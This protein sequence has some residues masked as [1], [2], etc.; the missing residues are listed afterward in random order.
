MEALV[1]QQLPTQEVSHEAKK[2][3]VLKTWGNQQTMNLNPLIHSNIVQSHYWKV[4]LKEITSWQQTVDEIY[5]CVTH[6]EPWE[7]GS[8]VKGMSTGGGVRGV[9]V[10][11]IVSTAF[12]LMYKLFTIK[13]TRNQLHALL[14][15]P[16]SPYI[17]GVGFLFIRYCIPPEE[18]WDWVSPYLADDFDI[19]CKA[20][21]GEVITIGQMVEIFFTKL[22]WY[23]TK[24]PR[25][26]VLVQKNIE[27]NLKLWIQENRPAKPSKSE[28]EDKESGENLRIRE[29]DSK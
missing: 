9:G 2:P 26:P 12:T 8:R 11:G 1:T 6:L 18:Q 24:F 21:G 22:D 17:R 10:K 16:D 4:D 15:H 29:K 3:K 23:D 20:G 13:M 7:R 27:K 25:F 5:N 14:D 19:D 28:S